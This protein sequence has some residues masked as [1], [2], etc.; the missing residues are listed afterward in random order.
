MNKNPTCPDGTIYHLEQVTKTYQ[1]RQVLEVSSL[2]IR[3]GEILALVGPS[4]AGQSTLLRL[5]NF[6][7]PPTQ[8][9]IVFHDAA[10]TPEKEMPLELR[11]RVTTVFQ[12]P[13][14][15]N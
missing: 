7:E 6:L 14:L 10:F 13:M 15:L 2:D 4:G 9:Q 8:G 5:L 11:R 1:G 12:R 3:Q